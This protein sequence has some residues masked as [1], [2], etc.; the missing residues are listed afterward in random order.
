ML[1][2]YIGLY[3]VLNLIV[4]F[5]FWLWNFSSSILGGWLGFL[6]TV[7]SLVLP[8]CYLVLFTIAKDFKLR[9]RYLTC[10]LS[11]LVSY[12]VFLFTQR[13]D[14]LNYSS[15]DLQSSL[16]FALLYVFFIFYVNVGLPLIMLLITIIKSIIY[17]VKR[18][19]KDGDS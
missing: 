12:L 11:A 1:K 5:G 16:G 9:L 4:Y 10:I 14:Y 13:T 3:I 15:T 8:I 2:K 18:R 6:I 19:N 17:L 7:S